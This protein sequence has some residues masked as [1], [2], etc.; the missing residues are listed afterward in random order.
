MLNEERTVRN[1]GLD[2]EC[3]E[4]LHLHRREKE[5]NK[6]WAKSDVNLKSLKCLAYLPVLP[7]NR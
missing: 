6:V 4:W 2:H 1:G 5:I 7:E 3:V